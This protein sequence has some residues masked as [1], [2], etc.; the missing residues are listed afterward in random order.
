M[1]LHVNIFAALTD[2]SPILMFAKRLHTSLTL[3]YVM[4]FESLMLTPFCMEI[5]SVIK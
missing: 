1:A 4:R 5:L 3:L 2:H